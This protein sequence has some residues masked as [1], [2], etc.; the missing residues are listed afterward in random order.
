MVNLFTPLLSSVVASRP[1]FIRRPPD[2]CLCSQESIT[3]RFSTT[4]SQTTLTSWPTRWR[5]TCSPMRSVDPPP[6]PGSVLRVVPPH[7]EPVLQLWPSVGQIKTLNPFTKNKGTTM[8]VGCWKS[9]PEV[10]GSHTPISYSFISFMV[11]VCAPLR[12]ENHEENNIKQENKSKWNQKPGFH[13]FRVFRPPES[14]SPVVH[15]AHS[16]SVTVTHVQT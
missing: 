13:V 12:R 14:C 9:P 1:S 11:R 8:T 10:E 16:H 6:P 5:G 15:R 4:F 3:V 2:S 7:S